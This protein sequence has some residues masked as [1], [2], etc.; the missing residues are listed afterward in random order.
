[1]LT[2]FTNRSH[3]GV[4]ARTSVTR[5]SVGRSTF[6]FSGARVNSPNSPFFLQLCNGLNLVSGGER[7]L[8]FF[9]S[10]QSCSLG[11]K[12]WTCLSG[13]CWVILAELNL[14]TVRGRVQKGSQPQVPAGRLTPHTPSVSD[15]RQEQE[16]PLG[17]DRDS[18]AVRPAPQHH[19]PQRRK[20]PPAPPLSPSCVSVPCPP[21]APEDA[22][23]LATRSPTLP[24]A[25]EPEAT[26][27]W[28]PRGHP[29][30]GGPTCLAIHHVPLMAPHPSLIL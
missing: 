15:H 3:P 16:G 4:R 25:P 23:R 5:G 19:H 22:G 17:G 26:A 2:S 29:A 27:A 28:A 24:G 9:F 12:G 1:M 13:Q 21:D 14:E 6:C 10:C 7:P 18:P 30:A 20:C 8:F 11:K